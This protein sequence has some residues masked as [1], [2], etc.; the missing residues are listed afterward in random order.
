MDKF[1]AAQKLHGSSRKHLGHLVR[2][3]TT[4]T[5]HMADQP[6]PDRAV[7]V[8]VV[9]GLPAQAQTRNGKRTTT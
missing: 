9:V 6:D 8:A 4:S 7:I 3:G 1:Y 2:A 5:Q